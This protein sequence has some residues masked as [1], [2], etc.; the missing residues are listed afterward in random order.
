MPG[1][2]RTAPCPNITGDW[3]VFGLDTNSP[4]ASGAFIDSWWGG[5]G[6]TGHRE[7]GGSVPYANFSAKA[8]NAKYGASST[9]QPP[10][11]QT[12]IIIKV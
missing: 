9:V 5:N 1:Y 11:F 2:V 4:E 10:A 7:K 12:L 8:S 3:K 6:Y